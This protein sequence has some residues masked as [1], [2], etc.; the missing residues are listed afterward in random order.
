MMRRMVEGGEGLWV[1]RSGRHF[2]SWNGNQIAGGDVSSDDD[3]GDDVGDVKN[4]QD[5][6]VDLD[7]IY[8]RQSKH[9]GYCIYLFD[10]SF[11]QSK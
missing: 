1:E 4:G 5:G 6:D 8:T 10:N 11:D 9:C 2:P 3:N 7:D